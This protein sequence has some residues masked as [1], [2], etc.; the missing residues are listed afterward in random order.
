MRVCV[1]C[2]IAEKNE[3]AVIVYDD[4]FCLAFLDNR[5]I[6][7]GHVLVIPKKHYR[8]ITAMP[9]N[10]VGMLYSVAATVAKA[11][12][13]ALLADGVNLGQSDGRAA[14]QDIFH[15]HVHVVPRFLGDAPSGLWPARKQTSLAELRRIG[16]QIRREIRVLAESA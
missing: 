13:R 8:G 11:V 4:P 5:P 15:A 9:A 2:R 10:E 16:P 6:N 12:K 1:F 3:R 7:P 14:S